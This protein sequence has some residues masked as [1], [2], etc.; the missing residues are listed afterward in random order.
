M[1]F[2]TVGEDWQ[3]RPALTFG[4]TRIVQEALSNAARHGRASEIVVTL[5]RL[6][7]QSGQTIECTV[8]DNG[9]GFAVET[10]PPGVG[11]QSMRERAEALGGVLSV[12]SAPGAGTMVKFSLRA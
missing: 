8:W 2:Q 3:V 1:E 4:L 5:S 11:L 12:Q 6:P 10:Q 9:A 7:G